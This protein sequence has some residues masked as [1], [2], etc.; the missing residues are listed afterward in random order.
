MQA[1]SGPENER[2]LDFRGLSPISGVT[3][4]GP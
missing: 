2:L 3:N 4:Q 1:T